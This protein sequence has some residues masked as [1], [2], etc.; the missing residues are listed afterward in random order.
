MFVAY[1]IIGTT[2][3]L[4]HQTFAHFS[5]SLFA[6]SLLEGVPHVHRIDCSVF[7]RSTVATGSGVSA[8]HLGRANIRI[9]Q[10]GL[11]QQTNYPTLNF[12]SL[13]SVLDQ[14][15]QF[16]A[17]LLELIKQRHSLTTA[18]LRLPHQTGAHS[19]MHLHEGNRLR[20]DFIFGIQINAASLVFLAA[21]NR[22]YGRVMWI[23]FL[24][25]LP[26]TATM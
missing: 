12:T 15:G 10:L 16:Y 23:L 4:L 8:F 9:K 19:W 5:H 13:S 17:N 1:I 26:E 21:F 18:L 11:L 6:I 24:R 14:F 3:S 25:H 7:E 20:C 2:A 22:L